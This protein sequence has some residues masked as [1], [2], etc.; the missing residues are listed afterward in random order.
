LF[1]NAEAIELMRRVNT[2]VVDKTG[3]LT[4]GKPKVVSVVPSNGIDERTLL[5]LAAGLEMGSE[6]PLAAAVV[7]SAKER[8]IEPGRAF[9]FESK[10]GNGVAAEIDKQRV[11]LGNR[12]LVDELGIDVSQ[13]ETTAE[14]LR[15]DG[16]TVMFV[17]VDDRV[18][19]LIGVADPIKQSAP[20]A[21]EQLHR[22]GIRVVM[23]TGD[24]RT[25]AADVARKL[26]ID[27]GMARA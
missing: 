24:N 21:I 22:E 5:R 13:F 20:E 6:H 27:E 25:T 10:T 17:A 19:G 23:V 14:E 9:A 18:K 26:N 15:R 1:R 3:T 16:Q 2:L 12:R 8:Q 4:E 11:A 7:E